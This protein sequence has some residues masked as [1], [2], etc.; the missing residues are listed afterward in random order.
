MSRPAPMTS[1]AHRLR[2]LLTP[3]FFV[4]LCSVPGIVAAQQINTTTYSGISITTGNATGIQLSATSYPIA[5]T[6]T[7]TLDVEFTTSAGHC[8]SMYVRFE[9]D[10]NSA[11]PAYTSPA[12]L[13]ANQSTGFISLGPVTPGSHTVAIRT[14]GVV[15]GCNNGTLVGWGG[16]AR[17]RT[18]QA[19]AAP[20]VIP[21]LDARGL[22]ALG[23]VIGLAALLALRRRWG[24]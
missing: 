10:G 9:L 7:G 16:T 6:T 15:G 13:A 18:S 4:A 20:A 23:A 24:A 21:T 3:L 17:V 14:E 11:S 2:G 1:L 22:G 8:S 5:V 12:P 19:A